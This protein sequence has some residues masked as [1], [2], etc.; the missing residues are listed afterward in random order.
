MTK[1][2]IVISKSTELVRIPLDS[3]MYVEADGNYSKIVTKDGRERLVLLQLG[4]VE[5]LIA[6]QIDEFEG[7][8]LRLGRKYIINLNYIHVIDVSKQL[9]VISDCANC[10]HKIEASRDALLKL[11]SYIESLVD[12][13]KG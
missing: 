2:Y 13:G 9:L 12:Y 10:Y 8:I 5:D 11:K 4:Q 1:Q 7:E 6:E 3:L